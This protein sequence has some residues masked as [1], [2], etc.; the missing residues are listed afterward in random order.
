MNKIHQKM[1]I[2]TYVPKVV[3]FILIAPS[4]KCFEAILLAVIWLSDIRLIYNA[5]THYYSL[6]K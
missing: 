2:I 1:K 6:D 5:L 3:I 4:I